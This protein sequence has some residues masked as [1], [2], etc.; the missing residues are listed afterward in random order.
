MLP[1]STL[2]TLSFTYNPKKIHGHASVETRE[3]ESGPAEANPSTR[4][5]G[6]PP[7]DVGPREAMWCDN[8][9]CALCWRNSTSW[10]R[11][12]PDRLGGEP[13]KYGGEHPK[14]EISPQPPC[15]TDHNTSVPHTISDA[16]KNRVISNHKN[17]KSNLQS[18][19]K[20]E[21]TK[22]VR[23]LFP[24]TIPTPVTHSNS[25]IHTLSWPSISKW[26]KHDLAKG[27]W[28]LIFEWKWGCLLSLDNGLQ[29]PTLNI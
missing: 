7:K 23:N 11:G 9:D 26:C 17:I 2:H 6:F 16:H 20:A 4:T 21:N 5:T 18:N 14:L 22:T 8:T 28:L 24:S 19:D 12:F 15:S 10:I 3:R 25:S 13:L 27:L 29:P 1:S